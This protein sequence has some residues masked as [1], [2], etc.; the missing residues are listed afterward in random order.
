M[1]D[2]ARIPSQAAVGREICRRNFSEFIK[3]AWPTIEPSTEYLHN[4]HIDLIGEHLS[5]IPDKTTRLCINIPP[6]YMKSI[7]ATVMWPVWLWTI[8]P[9][10]R[11][12]FCSYSA[13]LSVKHSVDRRTII[14]SPWFQE[15]WGHAVKLRDDQ[16]T[17]KEFANTAGGFMLSTS[18]GGS[19]T[20]RGGDIIVIDD[21]IN[22]DQSMSDAERK[23]ANDWLSI[24]LTTR[25]ND[26]TRGAIV[27]V[28]QRLHTDDPTASMMKGGGW[29]HIK[30][31]CPATEDTSITFPVSGRVK[32][33][34]T[35]DPLWPER[36]NTEQLDI[37]HVR[38]GS[39]A[40]AGQ[41][42]QRPSP[43]GGGIIK[44]DWF[45]FYDPDTLDMSSIPR[46]INSWDLT[47]KKEGSS[48]VGGQAWGARGPDRFLL[49]RVFRDMSFLDSVQAILD[50]KIRHPRTQG[51]V[52]EDKANGPAVMN[53]LEGKVTGVV[54]FDPQGTKIERLQAVS[55]QV[56]S[57]NIY[58][59]KG[60][61][62]L[63]EFLEEVCN[64]PATTY[65]DQVDPMTQAL[66]YIGDGRMQVDLAESNFET[67][68]EA[69]DLDWCQ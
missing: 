52:I 22:P 4:W 45:K 47:F 21:P 18:V 30:L 23:N 9:S 55:P 24:T 38:M 54:P 32:E 57:G 60:A 1:L 69:P 42:L 12:L 36:E 31:P 59:P 39:W 68:R 15:R 67:Q 11:F 48:R 43:L 2:A 10:L 46:I 19:A 61:P 29:E 14:R 66:L 44:R 27:L 33:V 17:K 51:I 64:F 3:R 40:F 5:Q 50:M 41:Y 26:K 63:E 28:M 53:V 62:W 37:Q 20:G 58:L 34:K 7:E 8:D 25:L 6:R 65:D 16:D 49:D 35:G 13:E 56:E